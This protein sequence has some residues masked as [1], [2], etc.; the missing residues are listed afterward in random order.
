MKD[1]ENSIKNLKIWENL[2]SL[3]VI[4]G[5]ITNQNFLVTDGSKKYFVRI[6][7]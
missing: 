4:K 7:F 6:P 2:I 5:G 1:I 3:E